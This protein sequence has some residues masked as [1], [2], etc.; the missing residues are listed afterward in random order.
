MSEEDG[1]MTVKVPKDSSVIV[2]QAT[3]DA[4]V[5]KAADIQPE[6]KE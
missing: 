2:M 4:I 3:A 1:M 6:T 5:I